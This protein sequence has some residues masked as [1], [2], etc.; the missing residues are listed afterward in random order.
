LSLSV[1]LFKVKGVRQADLTWSPTGAGTMDVYRDGALVA[2][3]PNDGA[4]IDVIGGRGG[5]TFTYRVCVSGASTCSANV[6]VSY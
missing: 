1:S 3:T 2:T 5:G 4:H 6:T